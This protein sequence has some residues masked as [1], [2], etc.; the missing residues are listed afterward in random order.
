[1]QQSETP[2]LIPSVPEDNITDLLE[3]R[4]ATTP[5]R[6]LFAVP[7]G[8]GWRDI[9][10]AEFREQVVALAKGFAAAGV[11]PGDRIAFICKTSYEWTLV[12]FALHYA[13]AVMVPVYETSSPLQIHWIV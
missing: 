8:E 3:Q 10:A 9:S 4:V 2:I 1:V 11:E 5:D 13:G 6:S 12:D 7:Q